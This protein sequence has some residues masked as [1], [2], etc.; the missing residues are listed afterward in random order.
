VDFVPEADTDFEIE[1]EVDFDVEAEA[2]AVVVADSVE[3][4]EAAL[5]AGS[6]HGSTFY[7]HQEFAR[8]I[9]TG[10]PPLVSAH[11]GMMAVAMGAAAERSA[12]EKRVVTI[13]EMLG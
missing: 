1:A 2:D 8:A 6:H 12:A 7:Q 10:H 3:V 5:K 13:A 4:D 9:R 11:D